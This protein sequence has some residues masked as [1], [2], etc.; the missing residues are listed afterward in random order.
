M[1]CLNKDSPPRT[2]NRGRVMDSMMSIRDE[3]RLDKS[4]DCV[5]YSV[6]TLQGINSGDADI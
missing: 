2:T 6:A 1:S 5:M 4:N 3:V